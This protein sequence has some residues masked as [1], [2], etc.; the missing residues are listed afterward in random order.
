MGLIYL[1]SS[2]SDSRQWRPLAQDFP[3]LMHDFYGYGSAP[4]AP[5]GPF[6]LAVEAQRIEMNERMT[7]VGHS[8]GAANA[9][10]LAVTRPDQVKALCLYEPVAFWLLPK[11]SPERREA[12]S[13]AASMATLTPEQGAQ[14][15]VDYWSGQGSFA[16]LPERSQ[17]KLASQA[18]KVMKDFEALTGSDIDPAGLTMPLLLMVGRHS[19][20]SSKAV[21]WELARRLPH[22]LKV[23]VDAGH[24]G[25]IQAPDKVFPVMA[26][27]LKSYG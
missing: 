25:P 18:P 10:H 26:E 2:M 5:K 27:F 24:M 16:A 9:L 15:F 21:A 1:H 12:E 3:G 7:L 6:S 22:C 17:Q 11:D 14:A 13:L 8:Y 20:A 23:E 4:Q 19:P